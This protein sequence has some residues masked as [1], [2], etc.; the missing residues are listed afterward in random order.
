MAT[1]ARYKGPR[2]GPCRTANTYTAIEETFQYTFSNAEPVPDTV[3]VVE[4]GVDMN[5]I[6]AFEPQF[7]PSSFI[8]AGSPMC[9][10]MFQRYDQ[11]RIRNVEV[12]ITPFVLNPQNYSRSSLDLVVSESL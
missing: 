6:K 10:S 11:F 8:N 12:K 9:W 7:R 4:P 2:V 1:L 3:Y 5:E